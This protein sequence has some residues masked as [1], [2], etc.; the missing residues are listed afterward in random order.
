MLNRLP[1]RIS[2]LLMALLVLTYLI[3]PASAQTPTASFQGLGQMPGTMSG[4]G[5]YVNAVSGDGST[6][7]GYTWVS[8]TATRSY[9]WTAAGGF[10][11]LGTL[12]GNDCSNNR[13]YAVSFDGS[14]VVGT[15]CKP[16][17]MV[18][19]FRWTISGG[20]QEI[21]M[22]AELSQE[23]RGVSAD[24]SIVVGKNIRWTAPGQIDVIPYLGGNNVT[25]AAGV[26]AD[27]QVVGGH[28]ETSPSRYFHAFRWTSSGGIQDLGVTNGTESLSWGIS[29]DGN[30]V[31]G[32]ARDPNQF[33]RAFRWTASLGMRDM[34]T[35]GGPMSTAHGASSDGSIIVGKSLITSQSSSLRAFRW[36]AATG[37]RDL[38]QEL[39]NTGVTGLE[40]W[41]LAVAADVSD[42]GTV[43]VGWGYPA[44]LTPAQPFIAVLPTS[45]GG[46]SATATPV[47]SNP[48]FRSPTANSADS[49]GDGNG[50][51][52]N[53]ANAHTDDSAN[54][55]D[56]NSGSGTSTSCT[57]SSK[58]KHRFFNYGF[59]I[60]TGATIAGI[61]V[62]LDA[63]ADSTSSS[64]KMCVQLSWDGGTT[65]TAAKATG[66]L[67]T[68]MNT[69]TLG[70]TTDTWGRTWSP[71]NFADANFQVRVINVSSSTSRD[72]FLDW[73]AVRVT[74]N[75]GGQ[76]TSPAPSPTLTSTIPS[77]TAGSPT[78]TPVPP[79]V[80]PTRTPTQAPASDTVSIQVAEY[81]DR[82]E[83][84]R[85]EATS[86]SANATLQVFVTSTN[87]LIGT[88][89]ND[90]GGR[91]SGTFSR[92]TNP[93][94]I[95]VRSS[96]GGSASRNVI[97]R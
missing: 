56:N 42:D 16:D 93:Q 62:R 47:P 85:V 91:Y 43:I 41:T 71:A 13:A 24:G 29:A 7:V 94:N 64:P 83:E 37:M 81:D 53:P 89:R 65:W 10:E 92:S 74:Y 15:S 51:E 14:V 95:T 58:D 96:L 97:E 35:L 49:G 21:Q 44:S 70:S 46:G 1:L 72:F 90:G 27:G 30:V 75:G 33:W 28:S 78:P 54:A 22:G 68:S 52:S 36:T 34:G 48:G 39:V 5:T 76:A 80:T 12:G 19:A 2:S 61:E 23:A 38:K 20:I 59:S 32:E 25:F 18:R 73:I 67:G 31:F 60:P 45:G 40:N 17:G 4:A 77:P 9:R 79:S 88:L 57:S 87:Q 86:T 69:F 50:F 66:T 55:A 6:L 82:D 3:S 8:G 84:L 26:S 11:D 63:R